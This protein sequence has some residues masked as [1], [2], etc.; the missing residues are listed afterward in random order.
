MQIKIAVIWECAPGKGDILVKN[1]RIENNDFDLQSGNP[2]RLETAID[3]ENMEPGA[4][5]TLV[6]VKTETNAFTFFLRD[7]SMDFPVFIPAY[8]VAVTLV[9]DVR[10]YQQIERA[11]RNLGLQTRLQQIEAEPEETWD[12]ASLN[13]REL[14]HSVWMGIS[15]DVRVFETGLR[16]PM[17]Y[18][19]WVWPRWHGRGYFWPES[20]YTS[21]RYGY[22]AGRGWNCTERVE[23]W[24]DEGTLPILHTSRID[25]DVRYEHISF[26]TLENTPLTQAGIRG[27]HYL[28]ADGLAACCALNEDQMKIFEELK[29]SELERDEETIF[30]CRIVATNT[31]SAPKYAFFKTVYPHLGW[32]DVLAHD[33]DRENGFGVIKDSDL[34]F[35]VSKSNGKPMKQQEIAVLL[36]PGESVVY[37]F[38]LP[39][40]PITLDRAKKLAQK[41]IAELQVDCRAFWLTKLSSAAQISVPEKRIDDMLKAGLL[42]LDLTTFGLEPDGILTVANGMYGSLAQET[43][44]NIAFYDSLGLHDQARRS[45]DFFLSKQD[46]TGFIQN[47]ITYIGDPGCVL[48]SIGEHYR[49]THD[50]EWAEQ[51][52]RKVKRT[53]DF[54][55]ASRVKN[56]REELRGLG[57]GMLD[58]QVADPPDHEKIYMLNAYAYA[59][60]ART[61]ELLINVDPK[62]AS[63][64]AKEAEDFRN[65]IRESFFES[66]AK[67]PV[68]PLGDGSWCPT[69]S[70]WVGPSG[71]KC[72]FEDGQNWWTHGSISARD[73]VIGPL[74]AVSEEVVGPHENMASFMLNYHTD[75]LFS[76]NVCGS[77]PYLS[78]HQ[79][80]HLLRGEVKPFIKAYYNTFAAL[81]DRSIYSF[82]EHFYHESPHKTHEEA[83]FLMQ[84]RYMLY[85]EDGDTLHILRGVPRNWFENGKTIEFQN[86][87][88]YFGKLSV[89]VVSNLNTGVIEAEITCDS[90][91]KPNNVVVRLPH[92]IGMKAVQVTGGKYNPENETILIESF[93]GHVEVKACFIS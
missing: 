83:E 60:L 26:T 23:R 85:M 69:V 54:I 57:Y 71:P 62:Y 93:S 45:I 64:I 81:A 88:S 36:Q 14:F 44:L 13:T 8:G 29:T 28:V 79:Y 56:K 42:H 55:V 70:P 4:H 65:D 38:I 63:Y 16:G 47:F 10:T 33:F 27:T 34:V 40:Q 5:P 53:C 20:D 17:V 15:R 80:I 75:L 67:G 7:V 2:Y 73:D 18:T 37:E 78:R 66:F 59:G 91:R 30:C 39:H 48:Y 46:E 74:H 35:G 92:P 1:G 3:A 32:G 21:C 90:E 43:W 82:W 89:S 9:D 19:D 72:L 76:R 22:L 52:A 11:I 87:A 49:Y 31:A 58:G 6:S 12:N 61:A 77:Q 86:V 50:D 68:V 51:I 41:D 84:T 25:D 24:L